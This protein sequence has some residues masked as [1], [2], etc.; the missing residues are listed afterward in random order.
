MDGILKDINIKYIRSLRPKLD[1]VLKDMQ[2][3]AD[4]NAIPIVSYEVGKFLELMT[5]IKDPENVLEIG[6]AIGFSGIF[7]ARALKTSGK[8]TT[9]ELSKPNIEIAENNFARAGIKNKVNIIYGDALKVLPELTNAYPGEPRPRRF[10]MVF[11]D[12]RKEEYKKYLDHA[13]N[14]INHN[15]IIIVDNLLWQGQTAG[16]PKVKDEHIAATEALKKFNRYFLKHPV[17]T[18]TILPVGDGTGLAILK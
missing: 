15:G 11:I 6:T 4:K 7:I 3:Y 9:I 2:S 5:L 18:S 13:I 10:D 17:I 12:A 1:P 8:L 14:L 16:G